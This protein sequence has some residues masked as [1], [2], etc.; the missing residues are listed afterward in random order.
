MKKI[1]TDEKNEMNI[2][3]IVK[4]FRKETHFKNKALVKKG[5]I[6]I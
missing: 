1:N 3:R 5:V 6:G 4:Q 2:L